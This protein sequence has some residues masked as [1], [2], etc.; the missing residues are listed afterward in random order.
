MNRLYSEC[1]DLLISMKEVMLKVE[2]VLHE[3]ESIT[4]NEVQKIINEVL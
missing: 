4:K 2:S 1:K 3:R